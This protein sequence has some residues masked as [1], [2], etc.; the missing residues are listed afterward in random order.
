[1]LLQPG[2]Q[3]LRQN[4]LRRDAHVQADEV[5][6]VIQ[7]ARDLAHSDRLEPALPH[8]LLAAPDQLHRRS[9][10]LLGYAHRLRDVVLEGAAPAERPS[11]T[12][13]P[14]LR[15][16]MMVSLETLSLG[17]SSQAMFKALSALSACHHVSATTATAVSPT[18]MTWRTPGIALALASS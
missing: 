1:V 10:D 8:I 7:A 15:K 4:G 14:S 11:V 16:A 9:R 6:L 5:S 17:P 2:R 13:S 12:S 3:R 18:F